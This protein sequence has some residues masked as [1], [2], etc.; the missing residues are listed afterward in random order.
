M[1]VAPNR[2]PKQSKS[3]LIARLPL[4][5]LRKVALRG[6]RDYVTAMIDFTMYGQGGQSVQVLSGSAGTVDTRESPS[7]ASA[8][9]LPSADVTRLCLE[10]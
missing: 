4:R 5:R 10:V 3:L 8:E 1:A 7:A 9:E 2:T 6:Q